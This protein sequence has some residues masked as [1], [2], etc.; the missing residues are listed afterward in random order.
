MNK[1]NIA[2]IRVSSDAQQT[3]LQ[4]DSIKEYCKR[5][6][7]VIDRYIEDHGQSAYKLNIDQRPSL[8]EIKELAQNKK[9]NNLYIYSSCRLARR[10][11]GAMFLKLL[12]SY[13]VK[14]ISMLEG[15]LYENNEDV[16][17]LMAFLRF[18]QNQT[19]SKKTSERVRSSKKVC[20]ENGDW[21]GGTVPFG[22]TIESN[23]LKIYPIEA[24]IIKKIYNI[25]I[26]SGSRACLN[27]LQDNKILT[28]KGNKWSKARLLSFL[29][30]SLHYGQRQ[31]KYNFPFDSNLAII[32]KET[33][34]QAMDIMRKRT[35]KKDS[36]T[37]YTNRSSILLES[38]MYHTVNGELH[39]LHID[40]SKT[41]TGKQ[42][43]YRCAKCRENGIKGIKSTYSNNKYF[44]IIE[45]KVIEILNSLS[46]EKI[47]AKYCKKKA[48]VLT[49]IENNI[50]ETNKALELKRKALK[51]ANIT[52]EKVF[53]GE[54][55]IDI[56]VIANKIKDIQTD[57]IELEKQLKELNDQFKHEQMEEI[58]KAK[59]TERFKEIKEIYHT[60][61]DKD[62][63]RILQELIN[64][65]VIN[66]QGEKETIDIKLNI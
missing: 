59:L 1:L 42:V 50:I 10:T 60:I 38:L 7:I 64:K 39:K 46:I 44:P 8:M 35:N 19:E 26:M 12:A 20:T 16:S 5:E 52:L 63:K 66:S 14:V 53:T 23:K 2:Y 57:I 55:N 65:V 13:D 54:L 9:I 15:S 49:H 41:S 31:G 28:R 25:Y 18:Y 21:L 58:K 40:Y 61:E 11:E 4:Y 27:F 17:E 3:D 48:V 62:K 47:E 30:N 24:E 36:H 56:T 43:L 6:K 34:L 45:S 33:Y 22:Y 29:K 51:N 37:R 32:P